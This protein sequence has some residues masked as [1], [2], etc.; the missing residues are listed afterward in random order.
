MSGGN[1]NVHCNCQLISPYLMF[2]KSSIL[3]LKIIPI[4]PNFE[5]WDSFIIVKIISTFQYLILSFLQVCFHLQVKSNIEGHNYTY[6]PVHNPQPKQTTRLCYDRCSNLFIDPM[7]DLWL[8]LCSD[9]YTNHL[10]VFYCGIGVVV[11][12]IVSESFTNNITEAEEQI[13]AVVT[14]MLVSRAGPGASPRSTSKIK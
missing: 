13:A 1:P 3:F 8:H 2:L 9:I 4:F 11:K 10:T 12:W 5:F 14:K 6:H 7:E